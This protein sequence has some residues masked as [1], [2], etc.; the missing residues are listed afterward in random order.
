MPTK[1]IMKSEKY[2]VP[3]LEQ[4]SSELSPS[5]FDSLIAYLP[6][7]MTYGALEGGNHQPNS[8]LEYCQVRYSIPDEVGWSITTFGLKF[9]LKY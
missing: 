2:K 7:K 5:G 4:R 9:R 3:T 8:Q 6:K 1:K